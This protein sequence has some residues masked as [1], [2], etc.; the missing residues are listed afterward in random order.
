MKNRIYIAGHT[1]LVGSALVRYFSERDD[2][3]VLTISHSDL[4]LTRQGEVEIFLIK[5]KPDCLIMAAGKVGGIHT[6]AT[7]PADFIYQNLMIEANLIH[8][9]FK[10]GVKRLLNFGSACIYPKVCPQ[11]MAPSLLMTGPVEETNGPYAMAKLAGLSL[12]T[13]YNK[14]HGTAYINA[15]PSNLYGPG[16]VFDLERAH[17]ISSLIRKFHEAKEKGMASVTLWGTGEVKRDFLFVD[18]MALACAVL[19]DHYEGNDPV[20][21][22]SGCSTSVR[23][24]ALLVR[25]VVG[26]EGKIEWD[27][28]KPDGAPERFLEASLINK[29]GWRP[30][31]ALREGLEITY[32]WW[33]ESCAS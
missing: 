18:D 24:L 2:V 32:H 28:S 7:Y 13:S 3:E 23:E 33:R 19:L 12:C 1:G 31:T 6:N 21:I 29:L 10:A 9:A 15:I 27:R 25:E 26:Y 20:N 11:P 16:D 8:G 4:D 22:G 30:K 5:T 14:Q 17:V